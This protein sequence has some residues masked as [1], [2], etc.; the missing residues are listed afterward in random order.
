MWPPEVDN[1]FNDIKWS[2][3]QA[4]IFLFF[5]PKKETIIQSDASMNGL[6]CILIQDDNPVCYAS[7]ALT[8]TERRYSNIEHYLIVV[9]WSIELFTNYIEGNHFVL[10]TYHKPC[11]CEHMDGTDSVSIEK[12]RQEGSK[13]VTL[14]HFKR[15]ITYGCPETRRECSKDRIFPMYF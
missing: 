7:R 9:M 6:G 11:N 8:E 2:I 15:I 1:A 5:D 3:T 13:D 4:P 14:Q 12:I 10:Q